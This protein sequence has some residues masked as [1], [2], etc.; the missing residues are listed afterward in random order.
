MNGRVKMIHLYYRIAMTNA[1]TQMTTKINY[2]NTIYS[3][4]GN[5][6]QISTIWKITS[7]YL[8]PY[9]QHL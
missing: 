8:I 1:L 7:T 5:A 6:Q 2:S 4:L 3:V 9:L